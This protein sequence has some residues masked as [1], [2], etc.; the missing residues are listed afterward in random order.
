MEKID[1]KRA[2]RYPAQDHCTGADGT[3]SHSLFL[4][5]HRL[6]P[7]GVQYAGAAQCAAVSVLHGRG[8]CPYP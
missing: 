6:H 5:I 2:G 3:G 4:R 7:D 8:L 1:E